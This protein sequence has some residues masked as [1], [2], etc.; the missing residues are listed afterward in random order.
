MNDSILSL[1]NS[2]RR[3]EAWFLVALAIC[4]SLLLAGCDSVFFIGGATCFGV[5][6]TPELASVSPS[7]I[8]THSLPATLIVTGRDF[9]VS[10]SVRMNNTPL[11]TTYVDSQHLQA[12]LTAETTVGKT[13]DQSAAEISV[14]TAEQPDGKIFGCP[15]GGSSATIVVIIN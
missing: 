4:A 2:S 12:V 15:N 3:M 5:T 1:R 8:D 7:T 13:V 14:F 11:P 10:S 9:Q 6:P